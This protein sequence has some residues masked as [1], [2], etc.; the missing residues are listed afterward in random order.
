[1]IKYKIIQKSNGFP[2][3]YLQIT[4]QSK[5]LY[6]L[7]GELIGNLHVHSASSPDFMSRRN[8]LCIRG[9]S[10]IENNRYI[11]I[12]IEDIYSVITTLTIINQ[13]YG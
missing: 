6:T 11:L 7:H 12:P 5:E 8:V 3:V 13:I 1:M 4:E 2:Y 9:E 10:Y